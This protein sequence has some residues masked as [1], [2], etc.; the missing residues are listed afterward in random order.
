M[1]TKFIRLT[2]LAAAMLAGCLSSLSAAEAPKAYADLSAKIFKAL[3]VGDFD[4]FMS[5]A[6]AAFSSSTKKRTF[7]GISAQLTP[8][9]KAGYVL[10]YLG[11]L[12]RS[13]GVQV[14]L[15]KIVFTKGGDDMP[16][17]INVKEG[18]VAGIGFPR[19]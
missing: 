15:W 14:T 6:D 3:E 7:D 10:A 16:V 17:N 9:L 5:D 1:N 8:Q 4:L 13:G 12:S 19:F 11:E 2:V 18:K